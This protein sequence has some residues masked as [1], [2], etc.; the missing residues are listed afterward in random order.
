MVCRRIYVTN[1]NILKMKIVLSSQDL[2]PLPSGKLVL[3]QPHGILNSKFKRT[4]NEANT[5]KIKKGLFTTKTKLK[6][7]RFLDTTPTIDGL[8]KLVFFTVVLLSVI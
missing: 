4:V 7:S 1:Q 8:F 5:S 6:T 3:T 2:E